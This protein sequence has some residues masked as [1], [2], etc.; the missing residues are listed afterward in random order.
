MIFKKDYFSNL[1][2][3]EKYQQVN[4]EEYQEDPTNRTENLNTDV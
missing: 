3:Q 2:I 4:R 1:K